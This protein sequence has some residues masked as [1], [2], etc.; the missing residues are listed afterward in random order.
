MLGSGIA[1]CAKQ[2]ASSAHDCNTN[3]PNPGGGFCC[4]EVQEG[5]PTQDGSVGGV[6]DGGGGTADGSS[7]DGGLSSCFWPASLDPT[8]AAGNGQ[9]V[10][11]RAYLACTYSNGSTE[12]CVSNDPT[13]CPGPAQSANG[14]FSCQN[15]CQPDEYAITC[16]QAGFGGAPGPTPQPPPASCR[17]LAG[18]EGVSFGCCPCGSTADAG[19]DGTVTQDGASITEA[20]GAVTD[21]SFCQVSLEAWCASNAWPRCTGDWASAV[22]NP[23]TTGGQGCWDASSCDGYNVLS[24]QGIDSGQHYYYDKSTGQLVAIVMTGNVTVCLGG[25]PDFVFGLPS[26]CSSS[27]LVCAPPAEGGTDGPSSAMDSGGQ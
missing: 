17:F 6:D 7:G 25:P 24:Q 9:C 20:G 27:M 1:R 15:R 14:T 3:P 10:A 16:G 11:G 21:A 26:A 5:G 22:A 23:A 19:A 2:A 13:Q 18:V 12:L 8:D 4:F